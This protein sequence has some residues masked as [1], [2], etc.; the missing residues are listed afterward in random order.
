MKVDVTVTGKPSAP[1]NQA[2]PKPAKRKRAK[3]KRKRKA[4][5]QAAKGVAKTVPVAEKEFSIA[6]SGGNTLK[7]GS[8][9]FSVKNIGKIQH[10]LAIA[11]GGQKEQKTP[12][13]SAGQQKPLKVALKP[14]KY[15]FFCTVPGHEQAGM[16]VDVTVR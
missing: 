11:G 8:Y 5:S 15:K 13:L 3:A 1:A 16:K 10:D 9:T 7:A 14:G 6:L 2:K 4:P 12:L